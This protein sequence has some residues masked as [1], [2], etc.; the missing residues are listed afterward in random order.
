MSYFFATSEKVNLSNFGSFVKMSLSV[1]SQCQ[2]AGVLYQGDKYSPCF[3]KKEVFGQEKICETTVAD[4]PTVHKNILVPVTLGLVINSHSSSRKVR[5]VV[6]PQ[7]SFT[8]I[9]ICSSSV[10]NLETAWFVHIVF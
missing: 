1:H 5:R 7:E 8:S 2:R 9:N 10:S 3:Q 4:S 6:T